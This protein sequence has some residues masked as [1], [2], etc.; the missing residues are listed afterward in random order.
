[1]ILNAHTRM[2]VQ[3]KSYALCIY[4][5]VLSLFSRVRL[6]VTLWTVAHQAPLSLGFSRQE[7]WG[8]LPCLPPGDLP[9]PGIESLSLRS[10]ALAGMFFTAQ[11]TWEAA[12]C[13]L[14]DIH[15]CINISGNHPIKCSVSV[16]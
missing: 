11:V 10:A 3:K 8:G 6:C 1:M 15:I 2:C 5:C 4:W 9:N 13:I 7:Y 12:P 14:V 16:C